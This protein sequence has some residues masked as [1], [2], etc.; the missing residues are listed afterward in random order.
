MKVKSENGGK[1]VHSLKKELSELQEKVA[2]RDMEL[3]R[4]STAIAEKTGKL[5]KL[6]DQ[7]TALDID[8]VLKNKMT[9]SCL[10][11]IETETIEK[12][13]DVEMTEMDSVFLSKLQ[14][15]HPALNQR[16]MQIALLVKLNY[17]TKD[18]ALSL[19]ITKRG[20]ESVRYKLHKKLGLEKHQSIKTY[21]SD[22]AIR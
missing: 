1:S 22:F 14:K 2:Y 17:D 9:D 16:E 5:R 10:S 11:L 13:L 20:M 12:R 21:L 3:T 15:K 18:I 7:I 19:G 6:F 4:V 8:P